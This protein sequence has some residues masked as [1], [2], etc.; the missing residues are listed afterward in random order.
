MFDNA[1]N[2]L[3]IVPDKELFPAKKNPKSEKFP[4][5]LGIVPVS[6]LAPDSENKD[7]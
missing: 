2:S 6:V 5:T 4:I 3:G 7:G 1:P